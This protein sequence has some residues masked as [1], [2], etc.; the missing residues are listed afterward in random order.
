MLSYEKS[1][2]LNF[3]NVSLFTFEREDIEVEKKM[4]RIKFVILQK[5]KEGKKRIS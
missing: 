2:L 4:L 3:R 5:K 1:V